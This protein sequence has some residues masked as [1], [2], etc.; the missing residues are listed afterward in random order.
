[1]EKNRFDLYTMI[2]KANSKR[3]EDLCEN[4]V[5]KLMKENIRECLSGLSF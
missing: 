1:M 3:I 5:I 4:E 2:L